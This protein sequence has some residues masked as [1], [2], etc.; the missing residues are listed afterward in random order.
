M[1]GGRRSI[2]TITFSFLVVSHHIRLIILHLQQGFT[3][4]RKVSHFQAM[5]LIDRSSNWHEEKESEKTGKNKARLKQYSL[6]EC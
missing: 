2:F 3:K 6:S 1:F 5:Y 4:V